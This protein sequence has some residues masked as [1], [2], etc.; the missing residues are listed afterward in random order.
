MLLI[1][2]CQPLLTYWIAPSFGTNG[3]AS[4]AV[5]AIACLFSTYVQIQYS[6]IIAAASNPGICVPVFSVAVL[7]HIGL[8]ILLLKPWG[9]LGVAVAFAL[10]YFLV[11]CYLLWW[12]SRNIVRVGVV[13]VVRDCFLAAWITATVLG[14]AF[15]V[16]ILPAVHGLF[17][18][19]AAFVFGY[20]AYVVCC[21]RMAYNRHERDYFRGLLRN[22]FFSDSRGSLTLLGDE[23]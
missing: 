22:R 2:F 19:L 14:G 7:F 20:I 18:V 13:R 3:A 4:L 6:L 17:S 21:A 11:F 16:L 23:P 5:L 9:I 1:V 12:V 10:A 15:R 8:S